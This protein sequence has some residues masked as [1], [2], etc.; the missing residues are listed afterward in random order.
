[1]P[2][3]SQYGEDRWIAEHLSLATTGLFVAV[4]A[5]DG[6]TG[7]NTLHFEEQGWTGLIIEP[8]PRQRQNLARN[9]RCR[10]ET[11]AIGSN[12]DAVFHLAKAPELSGFLRT[13]GDVRLPVKSLGEVLKVQGIGEIDLLSI[14]TEGTEIDVWRSFD[15]NLHRPG[16]VILEYET[17]A[18]APHASESNLSSLAIGLILKGR[19][20][21]IRHCCRQRA[22]RP[23]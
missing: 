2:Y 5:Y 18:A 3:Y 7:S 4:G 23:A 13:G 8:D 9:R 10:V 22:A 21:H 1:M 19:A 12:P 17:S 16:V 14:D 11:S 15:S 20:R 6:V